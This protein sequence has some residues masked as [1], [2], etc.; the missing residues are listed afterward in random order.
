MNTEFKDYYKVLGV[1]PRASFENIRSAAE[2]ELAQ[3]WNNAIGRLETQEAYEVL[4]DPERRKEYDIE[5]NKRL[6]ERELAIRNARTFEEYIAA[7]SLHSELANVDSA[8]EV[9]V[10]QEE[11]EQF[12]VSNQNSEYDSQVSKTFEENEQEESTVDSFVSGDSSEPTIENAEISQSDEEE[13][14]ENVE[15]TDPENEIDQEQEEQEQQIEQKNEEKTEEEQQIEQEQMPDA[16]EQQIIQDQQT[17][18]FVS[19]PIQ[20]LEKVQDQNK[21]IKQNIEE[22]KEEPIISKAALKEIIRAAIIAGGVGVGTLVIGG[23]PGVVIGLMAGVATGDLFKKHAK[24]ER[25][26]NFQKEPKPLEVKEI[27]TEET[28]LFN[29]YAEKLE[30]QIYGLLDKPNKNY[31]LEIAIRK[32]ANL[33]ELTEKRIHF[34]SSV[35]EKNCTILKRLEIIALKNKLDSLEKTLKQLQEKMDVYENK[36]YSKLS[37]LNQ[38]I[39]NKSYEISRLEDDKSKKDTDNKFVADDLMVERAALLKKRDAKANRLYVNKDI[40]SFGQVT[41]VK[42]NS[43]INMVKSSAGKFINLNEQDESNV[44]SR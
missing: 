15:E 3:N 41:L 36:K 20:R 10:S 37:Q 38:K 1:T 16:E 24:L 9:E 4:S 27:N 11:I 26:P 34:K 18:Q 2:R 28:K 14:Q 35:A 21:P 33:V 5:F 39:S 40:I 30:N 43:T 25:K 19:I 13:T 8:P 22:T 23:V 44:K 29:E 12:E 6:N 17:A 32:Y 31:E 42:L 7:T